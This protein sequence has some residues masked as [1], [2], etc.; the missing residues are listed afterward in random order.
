MS[1]DWGWGTLGASVS[2]TYVDKYTAIANDTGLAEPLTV[3]IEVADRAINKW[4]TT[5]SLSWASESWSARWTARYLSG[6]TESCNPDL[7]E[8]GA[9]CS[10]PNSDL[11]GGT[12]HLGATTFHDLRVNWKL[13]VS[14]DFTL[15]AGVNNI[16][17]K[18]PPI[19]VS[20]S[21][22]GYDAG[23]YDLPG[24]YSYVQAGVRF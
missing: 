13:P 18:D 19:C 9:V 22:N 23:T 8:A 15:S 7:T 14:F 11:S 5:A 24:R 2:T 16:F 4:R 6:L 12:N 21:L 20:C 3:G 17:G 1:P 10:N